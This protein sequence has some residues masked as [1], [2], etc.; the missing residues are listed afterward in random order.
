TIFLHCLPEVVP[1]PRRP[2]VNSDFGRAVHLT[3]TKV[4]E[5]TQKAPNISKVV[6][7]ELDVRSEIKAPQSQAP[8]FRPPQPAPGPVAR[9]IPSPQITEPP[10]IQAMAVPPPDVPPSIAPP[11]SPT[12]TT[13]QAPPPPSSSKPKI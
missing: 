1:P 2:V 12:G 7:A 6:R 13:A 11:P 8:K 3:M 4:F 5:P 10:K 9:P